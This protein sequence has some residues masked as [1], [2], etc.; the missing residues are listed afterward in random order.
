MDLLNA[1]HAVPPAAIAW[2]WIA[3]NA[4]FAVAW[5]FDARTHGRLEISDKELQVHRLILIPSIGMELALV[6]MFWQPWLCLPLFLGCYLVRTAHELI[7]ELRFHVDRCAPAEAAA[8]LVMWVTVHTKTWLVFGWAF[9]LRYAGWDSLH[10]SATLAL[11]STLAVLGV[12]AHLELVR[13]L[14][15]RPKE[16]LQAL[17]EP[18]EQ[19][20]L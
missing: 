18:R 2:S 20:P 16:L 5:A 13:G 12:I 6:G 19:V 17:R 14:P 11:G 4:V 8:H 1:L 7:D 3:L 10:W 15:S 9:L